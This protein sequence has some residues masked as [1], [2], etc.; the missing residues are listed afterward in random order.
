MRYVGLLDEALGG[1]RAF[2]G[3]MQAITGYIEDQTAKID[4][5]VADIDFLAEKFGDIVDP[6][7]QAFN[8]ITGFLESLGIKTDAV[9]SV[10]NRSLADVFVQTAVDAQNFLN[11]IAGVFAGLDGITKNVVYNVKTAFEN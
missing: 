7:G 11:L 8:S 3:V 10:M 1:S 5:L 9:S 2:G 4:D 6:I